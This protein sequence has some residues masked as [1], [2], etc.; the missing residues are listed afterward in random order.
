MGGE[1][2]PR[3]PPRRRR[4]L[5]PLGR[6]SRLPLPRRRVAQRAAR[7]DGE[8]LS[9]HRGERERPAVARGRRLARNRD[10]RRGDDA[11]R[12]ADHGL[13]V[14]R[15]GQRRAERVRPPRRPSDHET[16]ERH[17][18]LRAMILEQITEQLTEA[19]RNR[20][21]TLFGHA[22]ERIVLQAPPRLNMG[23]LATPVALE[24]AKALKRKPREIAETLAHGLTLPMFVQS[25]SVEGA[26]Y[27]N[28]RFDRGAFTAA[29]IRTVMAPARA[30][31]ERVIVEHTNI[32]PNKAAHI[33]HLRNAALGDTLARRLKFRRTPV[34]V[35]NY[36]D[37]LGVQVADILVGFRQLEQ[38]RLEDVRQIADSTRFDYYCWDLYSRVTEW[39][40]EDRPRLEVR[41]ATLHD[42]ERGD[43]D[44]AAMAAFVA[45][46]IVRTHLA[47]MARLNI[48]YDLLT[49][50]GDIIRLQF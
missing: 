7:A 37:D 29:H 31:G 2:V 5:P 47:T 40:G 17:D 50:E 36:I 24:L 27:L 44:T 11:P 38:R 6:R 33:G 3:R 35:Q 20:I 30:G 32:N 49:H 48:G 39:D 21:L 23:D 43:N 46:R 8:R 1:V 41:A 12:R 34:E 13:A 15:A 42:L 14:L 22:A 18:A 25:V 26:G 19:L 45:E 28:F 4:H 9:R 16:L 10:S